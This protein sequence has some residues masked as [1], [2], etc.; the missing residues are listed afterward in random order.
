MIR[1]TRILT[2]VYRDQAVYQED[3]AHWQ[4]GVSRTWRPNGRVTIRSATLPAEVIED[5]EGPPKFGKPDP[6]VLAQML[7]VDPRS[8]RVAE[9]MRLFGYDHDPA[10]APY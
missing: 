8:D 7:D 4:A 1:V 5:V 3:Q 2:Y 9:I 10:A 6:A